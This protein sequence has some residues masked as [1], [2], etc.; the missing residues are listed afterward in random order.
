MYI[1]TDTKNSGI[2]EYLDNQENIHTKKN[3]TALIKYLD[4]S[5]PEENIKEKYSKDLNHTFAE[6]RGS[7]GEEYRKKGIKYSKEN[8]QNI[9]ENKHLKNGSDGKPYWDKAIKKTEN[10]QHGLSTA[11]SVNKSL[12]MLYAISNPEFQSKIRE[13][14]NKADEQI[15]RE[16]EKL[17]LPSSKK[18]KYRDNIDR[19]KTKMAVVEFW[20]YESR[21]TKEGDL[22]PHLH[23]HKQIPNFAE[24]TFK[25][26]SKK[27]MAISSEQLLKAQKELTSKFNTL[28]VG[29]LVNIGIQVEKAP[30]DELD[31]TFRVKGIS[32]EQELALSSRANLINEHLNKTEKVFSTEEEKLK[33]KLATE[34]KTRLEKEEENANQIHETLKINTEKFID[35][36]ELIKQQSTDTEFKLINNLEQEFIQALRKDTKLGLNGEISEEN[37]REKISNIIRFERIYNSLDELNMCIDISFK[38]FE[39]RNLIIKKECG[40]YTTLDIAL[41]ESKVSKFINKLQNKDEFGKMTYKEQI[42]FTNKAEDKLI[43]YIEKQTLNFNQGQIDG[44]L[45]IAHERHIT[46]IEG[47]AGTGKTSTVIK[48]ANH[49]YTEQNKNVFGLATQTKTANSLKEAGIKAENCQSIEKFL[50]KYFD[51]DG[52]IKPSEK[53]DDKASAAINQAT[54]I[55]DEAGMVG[56]EHY[57]KLT[58]LA[59]RNNAKLILVGDPKQ[60]ASVAYGNPLRGIKEA[61]PD[62]YQ[63]RLTENNRQQT[64]EAQAIAENFRDKNPEE[65][66]KVMKEKNLLKL[67]EKKIDLIKDIARDYLDCEKKSKVVLAYTNNDC[68]LIN[69]KIRE[70]KIE[71]KE[72]DEEYYQVRIKQKA[73][74]GYNQEPIRNFS[75]RDRIVFTENITLDDKDKTK[76]LNSQ[77]AEI[78]NIDTKTGIFT[79]RLDDN[80][81]V[82]L[83]TTKTDINKKQNN[84]AFNHAYALT[85]YKSQGITVDKCFV[86]GSDKMTSNSAYVMFSRHKEEVSLYLEKSKKDGFIQSCKEEQI[87]KTTLNNKNVQKILSGLEQPPIQQGTEIG[88][89]GTPETEKEKMKKALDKIEKLK[90]QSVSS[91]DFQREKE[92]KKNEQE[93]NKKELEKEKSAKDIAHDNYKS[94]ILKYQTP[95]PKPTYKY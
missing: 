68:N 10:E 87:K 88:G 52:N 11:L 30:E 63:Q 4:K 89:S 5:M 83:D 85:A 44:M 25:D 42:E 57:R 28:L 19:S 29:E 1:I 62:T 9:M 46:Y 34:N 49:H 93:N 77:Q 3:L 67:K 12:S 50:T 54:I 40:Q 60:L 2:V 78:I 36:D 39:K 79:L 18:S 90:K 55:I 66:L 41:N 32:R 16:M 95:K 72:I 17:I 58:Q 7:L 38:E 86:L 74:N 92:L 76:L 81:E 22:E 61:L 84:N 71:R 82:Q 21:P 26:G 13:A 24:F 59:L 37:I 91:E 47:D 14:I 15:T 73:T 45:N 51:K 31:H 56:A 64:K 23:K 6:I 35:Y 20:H 53:L 65:A 80:K 27:T 8:F 48:Y 43:S 70:L 94:Q 75:V 33:Y 69:D